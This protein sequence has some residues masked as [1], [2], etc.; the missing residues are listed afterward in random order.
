MSI[1]VLDLFSGC[2]GLTQGLIQS[3]LDVVLSN[4]YWKPAHDTNKNNHNNTHHILGDITDDNVKE[5]I[6]KKCKRLKVN[7]IT[8]GPPCQAYSNAGKKDQFDNRGLLYKDYIYIVKKV[9]PEL[10]IIENVKGIL[11]ILHLKD[12]LNSQELKDVDDYK[13]LLKNYKEIDKKNKE[14]VTEKRKEINL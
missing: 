4:E 5:K 3:N 6:I 1:K 7:V 11:S 12:N 14:L 9:K 2:G 10:C 8:G 13:E